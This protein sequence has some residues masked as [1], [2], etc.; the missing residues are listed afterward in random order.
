[1]TYKNPKPNRSIPTPAHKLPTPQN[2]APY[3]RSLPKSACDAPSMQS[4]WASASPSRQGAMMASDSAYMQRMVTCH[5][6]SYGNCTC[7]G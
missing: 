7:C 2:T 6:N 5:D 4:R 3:I 1:M